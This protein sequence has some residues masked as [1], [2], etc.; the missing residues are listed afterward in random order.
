MAQAPRHLFDKCSFN[1]YISKK[2]PINT[3][4]KAKRIIIH[5]KLSLILYNSL[6]EGLPGSISEAPQAF[7]RDLKSG[8]GPRHNGSGPRHLFS[9]LKSGGPSPA[10]RPPTDVIAQ[11]PSIYS[12]IAIRPMPP[13]RAPDRHNGPGPSAFIRQL[14]SGPRLRCAAPTEITPKM[15]LGSVQL[16][17]GKEREFSLPELRGLPGV[18]R[19]NLEYDPF[20]G[21]MAG[22]LRLL[23]AGKRGFE[24]L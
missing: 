7:I 12:A 19:W 5:G 8:P 13:E 18:Y 15:M 24:P 21:Y 3:G 6:A 2:I 1:Y 4:F 9:K 22:V 14:K 16:W 10:A 17:M 11:A 20:L 23:K